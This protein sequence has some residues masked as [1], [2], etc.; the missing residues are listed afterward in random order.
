[1]SRSLAIL[2]HKVCLD[3][4]DGTELYSF[5]AGIRK[6]WPGMRRNFG[7][8]AWYAPEYVPCDALTSVNTP[9]LVGRAGVGLPA[10]GMELPRCSK[11]LISPYLF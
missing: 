11:L 2:F 9:F 5:E 7:P 3:T 6:E 8:L 10:P 4:K 1:M